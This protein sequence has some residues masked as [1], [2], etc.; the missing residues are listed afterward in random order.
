MVRAELFREIGGFEERFGGMYEDQAFC[1][2]LCLSHAALAIDTCGY[3]YR[4]H[5][6]SSSAVADRSGKADFGR[7]GFLTWLE[8]H[9][10]TRPS[11]D[12]R[13][14]R[15]LR[16]EQWWLRHPRLHGVVRRARRFLRRFTR[17]I[18]R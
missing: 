3:R 10:R 1:A 13:V 9:L 4:Q 6:D 14:W 5:T 12:P 11:A 15:A 16:R 18:P 2:K 7:A 17:A 8:E